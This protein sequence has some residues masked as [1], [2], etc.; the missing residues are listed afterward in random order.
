[1]EQAWPTGRAPSALED[2][3]TEMVGARKIATSVGAR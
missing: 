2:L 3:T 1:M